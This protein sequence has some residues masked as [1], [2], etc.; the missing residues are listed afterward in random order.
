M[1]CRAEVIQYRIHWRYKYV[2][3]AWWT[4]DEWKWTQWHN[5]SFT[6]ETTI[7][8]SGANEVMNTYIGFFNCKEDNDIKTSGGIRGWYD[9]MFRYYYANDSSPVA[10]IANWKNNSKPEKN[11][12][13][14]SNDYSRKYTGDGGYGFRGEY[15]RWAR[16]FDEDV[17]GE[18][19]WDA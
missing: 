10:K 6:H 13:Y 9:Y 4:I 11:W 12:S 1:A 15:S 2:W 5:E 7:T 14:P 19:T 8:C 17:P 18:S 3:L 16:N